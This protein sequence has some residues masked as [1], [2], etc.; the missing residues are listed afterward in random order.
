M[1]ISSKGCTSLHIPP[2]SPRYNAIEYAFSMLKRRYRSICSDS[3][4]LTADAED[5][6]GAI[7]VSVEL[8]GGFEGLFQ[9][10]RRSVTL[11]EMSTSKGMP[12]KRY[13]D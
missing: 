12:I 9:K 5:Y 7:I 3:D 10:V 11:A 6:Y 13:D 4:V 8:T 2:Y 1:V